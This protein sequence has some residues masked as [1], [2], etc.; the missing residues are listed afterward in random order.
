MITLLK[1]TSLVSVIV[2]AR[3]DQAGTNI[4]SDTYQAYVPYVSLAIIYLVIVMI[5]TKA[6]RHF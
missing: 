1:E 2:S 3:R 4:V 5:L 6:A